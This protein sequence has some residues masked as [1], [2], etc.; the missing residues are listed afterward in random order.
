MMGVSGLAGDPGINL[1]LQWGGART[2]FGSEGLFLLRANGSGPILLSSYGAIH[3]VEFHQGR[4]APLVE[5]HG[6]DRPD[7]RDELSRRYT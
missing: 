2:F 7:R 6:G 5:L 3:R 1:D 4:Q